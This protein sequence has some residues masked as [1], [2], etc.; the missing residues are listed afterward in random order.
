MDAGWFKVSFD[1]PRKVA[2]VHSLI[3]MG[4]PAVFPELHRLVGQRP[5]A[6]LKDS[7]RLR[8]EVFRSL[9]TA[10]VPE[11]AD[12]L[13]IGQRFREPEIVAACR[14]IERRLQAPDSP[15]KP[16]GGAG[17]ASR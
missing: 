14:T 17:G 11:L 8:I 10:D 15:S 1:L 2:A 16:R 3:A 12:F 9:A 4:D 6:H 7:R 13:R 5:L